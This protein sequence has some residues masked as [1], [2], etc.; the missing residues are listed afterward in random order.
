[1][2][3]SEVTCNGYCLKF[4]YRKTRGRRIDYALGDKRCNHCEV[5][6]KYDGIFCPCC[7]IRLRYT[8]RWRRY[9]I[10]HARY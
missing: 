3:A 7:G 8:S 2:G 5:Y 9:Q 1:M 10:E 6:L 4:Q